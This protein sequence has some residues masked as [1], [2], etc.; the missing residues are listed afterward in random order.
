MLCRMKT[1]ADA[2]GIRSGLEDFAKATCREYSP[3]EVFIIYCVWWSENAA[4]NRDFA[5]ILRIEGEPIHQP[6]QNEK[7][8]LIPRE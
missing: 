8:Q 4:D 5:Y 6:I 1:E 3:A 7:F 2:E